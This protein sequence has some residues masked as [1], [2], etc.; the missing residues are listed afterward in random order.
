MGWSVRNLFI[1]WR[2]GNTSSS[3][4]QMTRKK[5]LIPRGILWLICQLMLESLGREE[6]LKSTFGLII[7]LRP[8]KPTPS[9]DNYIIPTETLAS[10]VLSTQ[11]CICR[12]QGHSEERM[13]QAPIPCQWADGSRLNRQEWYFLELVTCRRIL[14]DQGKPGKNCPHMLIILWSWS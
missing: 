1:D 8:T 11:C 9:R 4:P 13:A 3:R 2:E 6:G 10:G 5:R 14:K 12:T 7:P